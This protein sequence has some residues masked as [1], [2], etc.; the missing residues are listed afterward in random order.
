MYSKYGSGIYG[1]KYCSIYNRNTTDNTANVDPITQSPTEV[2]ISYYICRG[3]PK[4]LMADSVY[5]GFRSMDE[6]EDV[7]SKLVLDD[8]HTNVDGAVIPSMDSLWGPS[9]RRQTSISKVPYNKRSP[10]KPRPPE[11]PILN[12]MPV[13]QRS[14]GL[15]SFREL[16]STYP[17]ASAQELDE[18]SFSFIKGV[19][20]GTTN[21]LPGVSIDITN[22]RSH[23]I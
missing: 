12:K 13:W 3:R 22:R 17:L 8:Y 16:A 7:K 21:V 9:F 23:S 6:D 10:S 4:Q 18:S 1:L 11:S 15:S 14:R 5:K 19:A 2:K 20:K